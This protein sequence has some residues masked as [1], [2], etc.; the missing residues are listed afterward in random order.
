MMMP[1]TLGLRGVTFTTATINHLL[2]Y[3][4]GNPAVLAS[5]SSGPHCCGNLEELKT[6]G[7]T[8]DP[9]VV[10]KGMQG[11]GS[12]EMI[13]T[14]VLSVIA[15]SLKRA[16]SSSRITGAETQT[17]SGERDTRPQPSGRL[18]R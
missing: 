10:F 7:N 3:R 2:H 18:R 13:V 5:Q 6:Q 11:E 17:K 8:V 15:A 1:M 16:T 4:I 12:V 9:E 14:N